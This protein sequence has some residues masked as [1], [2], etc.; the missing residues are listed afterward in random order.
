MYKWLTYHGFT[1]TTGEND[2]A[3]LSKRSF[4]MIKY[5]RK[6]RWWSIPHER[7]FTMD[8]ENLVCI[9]GPLYTHIV[10]I[11]HVTFDS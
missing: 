8:F 1:G 2:F 10:S 4:V 6:S 3:L 9:E 7:V 11:Y 5:P